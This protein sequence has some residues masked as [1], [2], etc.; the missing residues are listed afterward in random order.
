M[1]KK[2]LFEVYPKSKDLQKRWFV[3][4]WT[5][6]DNNPKRIKLHIPNVP[7]AQSRMQIAQQIISDIQTNGY[8]PQVQKQVKHQSD[9]VTLLR[10]KFLER[11]P[12]LRRKTIFCYETV[13]SN[14]DAFISGK[15][16]NDK[17]IGKLF[18]KEISLSGKKNATVNKHRVVLKSF[19][20]GLVEDEILSFNPFGKTT[21]LSN[22][23]SGSQYFKKRQI[24]QIKQYIHTNHFQF[25][26]MPIQWQYYCFIRPGELRQVRVGDVDWDDWRIFMRKEISKNKKDEWVMIP[27]GFR[28]ELENLNLHHFPQNFYLIGADGL[29][30]AKPVA[31]NYW[32]RHHF[33]V[34]R[35]L[36]F[37]ERYNFY[38]WKHT[39]VCHAFKNDMDLRELQTQLRHHSLEM[40]AIYLKSMG[41]NDMEDARKKHPVI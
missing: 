36:N 11:K 25:L 20:A 31:Q 24:Q 19:Y 41:A 15:D 38:S 8:V 26:W 27:D 2:I 21:K 7:D 29:P 1:R 23:S 9:V 28:K 10:S 22:D 37:S 5:E 40:V 33:T 16:A 14:Y 34:L 3:Q 6:L 39:G 12:S 18:L 32:S 13:L 17:N 4:F 30:S 35:N